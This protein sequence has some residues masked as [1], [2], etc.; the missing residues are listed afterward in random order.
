MVE[1]STNVRTILIFFLEWFISEGLF[2]YCLI[3]AYCVCAFVFSY[4][5]Q[6]IS[7]FR[8]LLSKIFKINFIKITINF[9]GWDIKIRTTID[10]QF[11]TL[12][13]TKY[14]IALLVHIAA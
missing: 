11:C 6:R 14:N 8:E 7:N 3:S 12:L 5:V 13:Y 2:I 10:M 1:L 4:F 9:K